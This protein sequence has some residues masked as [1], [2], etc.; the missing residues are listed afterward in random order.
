MFK[1]SLISIIILV[2]IYQVYLTYYENKNV[3]NEID[4]IEEKENLKMSTQIVKENHN[5]K[6]TKNEPS[7]NFRH[8]VLGKPDKIIPEGYLFNIKNPQ[9]WNVIVFNP[10]NEMKYL[11]VIRMNINQQQKNIFS[12]KITNWYEFIPGISF[13]KTTSE[14]VVPA[15]DENSALAVT[16][17]VINNL[18]G[19]LDFKN[20]VEN[21]LI[22]ISLAKI[23]NYS[24]IRT[25]IIEQI[26]ESING[27]NEINNE[28]LDYEEDLAETVNTI[29]EDR[30]DEER[31]QE[32]THQ[33]SERKSNNYSQ[34]EAYEGNEYSYI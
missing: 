21:K 14:L 3:N 9:P 4:N 10:S 33:E 27:E 34:P 20:I 13:N 29:D 28:S 1:E 23:R 26:M 15:P 16:N 12:E 19:D 6:P 30:Y 7:S 31:Y 17:L 32:E 24:S 8:P 18:K 5:I 2:V 25:K 22:E 11:F